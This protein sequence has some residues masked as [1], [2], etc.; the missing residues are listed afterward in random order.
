V[1]ELLNR[2][3]VDQD[4]TGRYCTLA[5]AVV[6]RAPDGCLD[7]ELCLSGHDRPVLLPASGEPRQVGEHG[8]AV[9]LLDEVAVTPVK[10][11]LESGDALV[12]FTDGVTERRRGRDLFGRHRL[13][14]ELRALAAKPPVTACT[15]AAGVRE[16]ALAFS[17]DAPRDDIA[18]L[19]LRND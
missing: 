12:F 9:G 1:V 14:R 6:T 2:T 4:E 7:V 3:L 18:V 16:A 8:T 13:L 15:L 5:M 11:R 19:V 10:L 17:P